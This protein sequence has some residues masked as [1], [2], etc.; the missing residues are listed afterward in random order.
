MNLQDTIQHAS[1]LSMEEAALQVVGRIQG[2]WS[3]AH[4]ED[5]G[6]IASMVEPKFIVG[7]EGVDQGHIDRG[8]ITDD[9]ELPSA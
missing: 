9:W 5:E 2:E 7:P 8:E 4:I 6:R 3:I 1:G